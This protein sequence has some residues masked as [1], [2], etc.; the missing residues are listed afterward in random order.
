MSIQHFPIQ[1]QGDGQF[2]GGA[3]LEKKPIPFSHESKG[4]KPYSNLLYWARA[5]SDNGSTIG[6]HPHKAFEIMSFVLNGAIEHYDSKN[7]QWMP[8]NAGDVQIIRAGN[9]ISHSEKILP[10]GEIFQIWFDPEINQALEKPASYNDYKASE[11]ISKQEKNYSV[12]ILKG[13]GSPIQMDSDRVTIKEVTLQ[14]G[15]SI[16]ELDD[17]LVYSL[18]LL[19]GKLSADGQIIEKNEFFIVKDQKAIKITEAKDAVLFW[20]ETPLRPA[21]KTYIEMA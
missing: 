13:E 1:A 5:W 3:I 8:L 18:F 12:R 10:G 16:M 6:E 2:N 14:D 4:S 15:E 7:R 9:G 19:K 17:S 11:F 20:I 21:Y